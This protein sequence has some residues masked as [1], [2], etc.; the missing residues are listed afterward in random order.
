MLKDEKEI[1]ENGI[2]EKIDKLFKDKPEIKSTSFWPDAKG[3]Y[4]ISNIKKYVDGDTLKVDQIFNLMRSE[5]GK[6]NFVKLKIKHLNECYSYFY[7]EDYMSKEDVEKCKEIMENSQKNAEKK[8]I[9]PES[10]QR[11]KK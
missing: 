7:H 3:V 8:F 5:D 10:V 1:K 4:S 9:P 2:K 11:K 6:I